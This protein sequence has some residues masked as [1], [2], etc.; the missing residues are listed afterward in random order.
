LQGHGGTSR[1]SL[2]TGR[3]FLRAMSHGRIS[4]DVA[5][6]QGARLIA[7]ETNITGQTVFVPEGQP[8]SQCRA[9]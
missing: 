8:E 5:V 2:S 3:S 9:H 4:L 1:F 7:G 6:G